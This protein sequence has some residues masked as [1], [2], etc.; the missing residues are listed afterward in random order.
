MIKILG[1]SDDHPNLEGVS[2]ALGEQADFQVHTAIDLDQ[3]ASLL[4]SHLKPDLVMLDSAQTDLDLTRRLLE[5]VKGVEG[6]PASTILLTG[7]TSEEARIRALEMGIDDYLVK[8]ASPRELISRLRALLRRRSQTSEGRRLEA[9]GI[10]LNC[11]QHRVLID[12]RTVSLSPTEYRLLEF[13]MSHPEKVYTRSQLLNNVWG[14]NVLIDERT[15]DVH[16]RRLRRAL[17]K[18]GRD[19]AIQ[20]V[21]GFGYRFSEL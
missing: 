20:T 16:I 14:R 8:P 18:F 12:G 7:Q 11:D 15:V 10:V 17:L 21:R 9:A 13:F 5:Q 3:V 1:L 19:T 4:D 2:N 6:M